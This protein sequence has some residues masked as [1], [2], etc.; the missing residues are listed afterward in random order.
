[1]RG[2]RLRKKFVRLLRAQKMTDIVKRLRMGL[3]TPIELEAADEI[4]RLRALLREAFDGLDDYW[5]TTPEGVSWVLRVSE[6]LGDD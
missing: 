3:A 6:A 5:I 1:M 2:S 4:E